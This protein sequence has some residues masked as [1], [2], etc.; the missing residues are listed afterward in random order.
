MKKTLFAACIASLVSVTAV[1]ADNNYNDELKAISS[2]GGYVAA[3]KILKDNE[4][5]AHAALIEL[6]EIAAPPFMEDTRAKRVAEML[7]AAGADNVSIDEVGNVIAL[8]KGKTGKKTLALGAHMDTVFPEGTDVTVRVEGDKYFAPGISDNTR[9]VVTMIQVLNAMTQANIQTEGDILFV[10]TVGE[11]GLGDLRGV[12]HLFRDGGPKI[13]SFIGI[14]GGFNSRIINGG[15]GSIRYRVTFNGPGGHSWGRFGDVNP[16]HALGRTIQHFVTTSPTVTSSGP[17][18]SYNVGRI[19][20]GTS[21]NSIP[22]ESWMEIDM[23][24]VNKAKLDDMEKILLAAVD[25]A[26]MEENAAKLTGGDLTVEAKRIGFR[27]VAF[28]SED[29]A[30]VQRTMAAMALFDLKPELLQSSTDANIPISLGIPSVTLSRGG[31]SSG[32]HSLKEWWQDKDTTMSVE[33]ILLLVLAEAG[34]SQ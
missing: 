28:E 3:Q 14:D 20:G 9:G 21:V 31:I 23:R 18:T 15:V 13:D 1:W 32:A 30:I 16:H 10:G 22:G 34:L 27:P 11:E 7:K 8:K 5:N 17:R 2:S 24:S 4:K 26:L 19:G 33:V 12:K 25:K 6:T 29:L